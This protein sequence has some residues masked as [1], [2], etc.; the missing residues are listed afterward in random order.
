[1][2]ILCKVVLKT[3]PGVPGGGI[4]KYYASA[5]VTEV[6]D[7]ELLSDYISEAC[8]VHGADIRA[9][10]YAAVKVII[11]ELANSKSIQLGDLGNVRIEISS[12]GRDNAE[13]VNIT[14]IKK[15]RIVFTPGKLIKKM[16]KRLDY[17][18]V[19]E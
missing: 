9:V 11:R 8:T 2:A 15:S 16:L 13:E 7:I 14:V 17:K 19:V 5:N 18:F 12:E 3:E 10:L 1:M 4:K 6:I